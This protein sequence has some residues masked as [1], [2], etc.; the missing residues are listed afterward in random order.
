[1]VTIEALLPNS[2]HLLK[3]G[4]AAEV[5]LTLA[6]VADALL[7]PSSVI[8]ARAGENFVYVV[9][10]KG[11]AKE[12]QVEVGVEH[13]SRTEI[14]KGLKQG[15]RIVEDGTLS[16]ADGVIIKGEGTKSGA[17]NDKVETGKAKGKSDKGD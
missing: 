6:H 1:M 5:T 7:V 16:L 9:N 4:M 15:E 17:S 13:E 10:E 3:E 11:E 8:F 14:T 12:R 2:R